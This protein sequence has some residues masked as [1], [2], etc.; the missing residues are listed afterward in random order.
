MGTPQGDDGIFWTLLARPL[1]LAWR[2]M[3]AETGRQLQEQ[4][5][6]LRL[7]VKNQEDSGVIG[8]K[9]YGFATDG[10]AAPFLQQGGRWSP[11]VLLKE[12]VSFTDSFLGYLDR[13]RREAIANPTGLQKE[14]ISNV[15]PPGLIVRTN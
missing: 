7:G 4:W 2:A 11:R 12:K 9:I 13:L 1:G 6:R 8:E 14:S 5:Y 3:L 10:P 15:N